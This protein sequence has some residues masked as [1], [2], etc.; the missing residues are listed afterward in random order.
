MHYG[1]QDNKGI[2]RSAALIHNLPGKIQGSDVGKCIT[3]GSVRGGGRVQICALSYSHGINIS[4]RINSRSQSEIT[5]CCWKKK[6]TL[7]PLKSVWASCITYWK[8]TSN[9]CIMCLRILLYSTQWIHY[10]C[11]FSLHELSS[12]WKNNVSFIFV[13]PATH[14][15][16]GTQSVMFFKTKKD[17]VK[18]H[19][20]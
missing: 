19:Q 1:T 14:T 13:S 16:L 20:C 5:E 4:T 6:C 9:Y 8:N 7:S 17:W 2:L 3:N 10:A 12:Y 15:I 11:L 18:L